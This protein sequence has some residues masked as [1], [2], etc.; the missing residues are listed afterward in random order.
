M[1]KISVILAILCLCQAL[2]AQQLYNMSFDVWSK[3]GRSW[4]PFPKEASEE[5]R[6]WDSAN[7][8]MKVLG[9]NTTTP[10][11]EHVAVP[12]PGKAAAKIVSQNVTWTFAAGSLFTGHFIRVVNFSGIEMDSGTPFTG[13]PKSLSGY[14]HYLPG[15]INHAKEPYL[16][17]KGKADNGQIEVALYDWPQVLRFVT[18]DGHFDPEADPHLIGRG[19]LLLTRATDGYVHF[20]I[21]I[22]YRRDA[23]PTYV[24]I[25]ILSSALGEYYTG[26]SNTVLYID[27]FQFNY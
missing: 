7:R 2:Q 21:P 4:N 14:Y 8:G 26:S 5:Q 9:V 10:E 6:V 15:T 25:N 19:V 24:G 20:E 23:T 3:Q 16:S 27:E 17:R 11:Y 18:N 12:G 1:K 22:E 13:R